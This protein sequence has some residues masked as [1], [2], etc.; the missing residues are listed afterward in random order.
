MVP[1]SYSHHSWLKINENAHIQ[2]DLKRQRVTFRSHS[3]TT[4]TK[5][6]VLQR[7]RSEETKNKKSCYCSHSHY[8]AG[9]QCNLTGQNNESRR[10]RERREEGKQEI[11]KTSLISADTSLRLSRHCCNQYK[12]NC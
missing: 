6:E 2:R 7:R 9:N 1:H 4:Q 5:G 3:L 8:E 12:C 10:E 11:M